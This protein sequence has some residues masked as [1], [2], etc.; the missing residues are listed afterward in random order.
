MK[1]ESEERNSE[2]VSS[3]RRRINIQVS[4]LRR[5]LAQDLGEDQHRI[6]TQDLGED[7]HRIISTQDLGINIASSFIAF[8]TIY[9]NKVI[10]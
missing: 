9:L 4:V 8:A 3:A 7:Q 10:R 6:S 1:E 2:S 5:R